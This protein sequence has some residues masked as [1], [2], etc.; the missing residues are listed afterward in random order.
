MR[1]LASAIAPRGR[2]AFRLLTLAALGALAGCGPT[3]AGSHSAPGPAAKCSMT[4]GVGEGRYAGAGGA[5]EVG[6]TRPV[7]SRRAPAPS[8]PDEAFLF[9]HLYEPLVRID[10]TGRRYPA[11]A[12]AWSSA[13]E[14]RRWTFVIRE[15]ARF[16]NG[17]PVKARDVASS[18]R[19]AEGGGGRPWRDREPARVVVEDDRRITVVFPERHSAVPAVLADPALAVV[20]EDGGAGWPVMGSGRYRVVEGSVAR[21]GIGPRRSDR[22]GGTVAFLV[23]EAASG[24]NGLPERLHLRVSPGADPRELLDA[25]VGLIFTGN[26]EALAYA[27]LRPDLAVRPLPWS[28][29]YVLAVHR[30]PGAPPPE[31]LPPDFLEALARDAV[32]SEARA[33]RAAPAAAAGGLCPDPA[34]DGEDAREG[35][36]SVGHRPAPSVRRIGYPRG[37]G[38]ARELAERLVAVAGARPVDVGVGGAPVLDGL[39]LGGSSSDVVATALDPE[40]IPPVLRAGWTETA[41]GDARPSAELAWVVGIPRPLPTLCPPLGA[42]R[43]SGTG[44][45][46]K[47]ALPYSLVPLVDTRRRAVVG[48]PG[49][50][51]AVD[52][53]GTPYL[54]AAEEGR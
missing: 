45:G 33:A 50:A 53:D 36:S 27:G 11:L 10:C 15:D 51:L 26:R 44:P 28:T 54:V 34:T 6:L 5:V 23:L 32:G 37:D 12:S 49:V 2:S 39:G 17:D 31:A 40:R 7:D 38:T 24:S 1:S 13:A 19:R 14:G 20:R 8:N 35:S 21:T 29:T 48:S 4:P 43:S 3:L 18:W 42:A 25:G 41:S 47:P 52:A 16:W 9:R 46:T 22:E 30:P